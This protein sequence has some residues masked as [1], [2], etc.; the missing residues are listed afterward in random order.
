[1]IESP[2]CYSNIL[3]RKKGLSQ[4]LESAHAL[5]HALNQ[6]VEAEEENH[7]SSSKLITA[8]VIKN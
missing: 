2:E 7:H 6:A 4:H 8:A 5:A 3:S 1:M